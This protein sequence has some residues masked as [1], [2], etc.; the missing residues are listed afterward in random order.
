MPWT[1]VPGAAQLFK[2]LL[3]SSSTCTRILIVITLSLRVDYHVK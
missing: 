3:N 1:A 2:R